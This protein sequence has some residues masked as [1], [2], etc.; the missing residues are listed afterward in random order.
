MTTDAD[1]ARRYTVVGAGAVGLLYGA[2]LAADG[3]DV[4]WIVRSTADELR[5]RGVEVA[6]PDG[7]VS[8]AAGQVSASNLGDPAPPA[9]VVVVATKTTGDDAVFPHLAALCGPQ[10]T[11]ALF[12]NGIGG[13]DAARRAVPHARAVVA[14]L[15]FVCAQRT[16]TGRAEH[17]DYG[18]VTLAPLGGDTAPADE[19]A[20]DLSH[21]GVET[22]VLADLGVARWRKLV[23]NIPFNGLCTVLDTR[24]DVLLAD[25]ASRALVADLMDEVIAGSVACGT[26]VDASFRDEMLKITDAMTPYAPS[27]KLD[28]ESGRDLEVE[29]IYRRPLR[30]AAEHGT[31]LPRIEALATML[32][33]LDRHGAP[34]AGR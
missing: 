1:P 17:L 15:C 11:I 13:E 27:M 6:S 5:R 12:Q 8:L 22:T 32:E 9:D 16:G 21:A 24:T 34:R 31:R 28:L 23:W 2:R 25:P 30:L 29:A 14:G 19:I 26:P 7:D 33:H 18:A 20:A 10:T 3:H 4:H